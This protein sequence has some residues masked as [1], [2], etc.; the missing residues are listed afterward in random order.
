[1]PVEEFQIR[2]TVDDD[3]EFLALV[4]SAIRG[5][6]AM[7]AMDQFAVVT[8]DNWFDDRW[9]GFPGVF[10]EYRKFLGA[11]IPY[12]RSRG[13][14]LP[15]FAAS[16]VADLEIVGASDKNLAAVFYVSNRSNTNLRG[17]LLGLIPGDDETWQWYVGFKFDETWKAIRHKNIGHEEFSG[18][19]SIGP[20]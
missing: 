14:A 18:Y 8:I 17:S 20:K 11:N 4:T 7:R 2:E 6:A 19:I 9:V 5:M 1:M 12:K 10:T 15:P 3:P 16:R 13:K